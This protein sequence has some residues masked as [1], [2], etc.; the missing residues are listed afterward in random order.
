MKNKVLLMVVVAAGIVG[1][2]EKEQAAPE[3]AS[4]AEAPPVEEWRNSAFVDH[5]HAHADYL[6]ELNY[7]LDDDDLEGAGTPAYWLSRHQTV[8]GLPEELLP[9]V[10]RMREAARAV[11]AADDLDTARAAARQVGKACT[12]CHEAAG[13]TPQQ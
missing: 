13:V 10:E 11:G 9:H 2:A 4:V 8:P 5:M 3:S 1:C 7:A 6:D 12:G